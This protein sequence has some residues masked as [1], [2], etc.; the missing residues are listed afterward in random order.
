[1]YIY[2]YTN[3]R[4]WNGAGKDG[5]YRIA[6][7]IGGNNIWRIAQKRKTIAIGR[8]KFSMI[9]VPSPGVGALLADLILAV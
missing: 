2:I 5:L 3:L 8:Y 9:A 6:G 4:K 7:Y 1:M